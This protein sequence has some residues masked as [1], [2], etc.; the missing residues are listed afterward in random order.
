MHCLLEA[1]LVAAVEDADGGRARAPPPALCAGIHSSAGDPEQWGTNT[2]PPPPH[3][4]A[5]A[6]MAAVL[7]RRLMTEMMKMTAVALRMCAAIPIHSLT[8][9]LLRASCTFLLALPRSGRMES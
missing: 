2:L 7:A 9:A 6:K 8:I 1:A 3:L 5:V 4:M